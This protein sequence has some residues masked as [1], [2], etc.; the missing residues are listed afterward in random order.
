MLILLDQMCL[1]H[2][3]LLTMLLML[4]VMY[5]GEL[6]GCPPIDLNSK[7]NCQ[8]NIGLPNEEFIYMCHDGYATSTDGKQYSATCLNGDWQIFGSC[9]GKH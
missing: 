3:T 6:C 5:A 2:S 7:T 9:I 8:S 4:T 1:I